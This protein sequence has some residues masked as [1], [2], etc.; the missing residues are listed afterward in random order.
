MFRCQ[1][2]RGHK[3]IW[4]LKPRH[5]AWYSML[6]PEIFAASAFGASTSTASL[7]DRRSKKSP[8][9]SR[10]VFPLSL[11]MKSSANLT[12]PYCKDVVYNSPL[13]DFT[14]ASP[15]QYIF[16]SEF[17]SCYECISPSCV[18]VAPIR[19][20]SNWPS[21]ILPS[22]RNEFPKASRTIKCVAGSGH[23]RGLP[24]KGKL[25]TPKLET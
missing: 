17:L 10:A 23:C 13:S 18:F 25:Q 3:Y 19:S 15:L 5:V 4:L 1:V 8:N 22:C 6:A 9:D 21:A 14:L 12:I 7:Q 20:Q 24:C 16:P 11:Y 2:S